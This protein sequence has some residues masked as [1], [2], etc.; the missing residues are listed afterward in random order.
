MIR[1]EWLLFCLVF[2]SAQIVTHAGVVQIG[3]DELS[4]DGVIGNSNG[5]YSGNHYASSGV[6]FRTG[7]LVASGGGIFT[8]TNPNDSFEVLGGAG[9]PAISRPN[10]AIARGGGTRDLLMI[11]TTPV[12][13]VSLI[14]D[15]Y[16]PESADIIR[17]G[18]LKSTGIENQFT[19]LGYD[20]KF[21]NATS[22]PANRLT[23][24]L[25]G[26]SFSYAL[27]QVTTESE[28]FDDLTFTQAVP[29]PA[30]ILIFGISLFCGGVAHCRRKLN[31]TSRTN[32][33]ADLSKLK[34]Q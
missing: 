9:Q 15:N 22:S 20:E 19:V 11:F 25:N 14:S 34:P 21:D 33:P 32:H 3:F 2:F 1:S 10:F 6:L 24:S 13:S 8:L 26:Q 23:I 12:T 31:G 7:E 5:V 18:A 29:E 28:G 17:L 16:F 4:A 27:F 30:S